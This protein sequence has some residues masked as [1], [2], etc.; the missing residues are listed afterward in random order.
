[1]TRRE[2]LR[3]TAHLC[4]HTLRN[5]AFFRAS[6]DAQ[7]A[8]TGEQ[9]WTTAHDNFLDIAVLEW[10]KVFA[11]EKRGKHHWGKV[12]NN[13]DVFM[14]GLLAH[15]KLTEPL[16]L[17][18]IQGMRAYRDKFIAHLDEENQMNIPN[19]SAAIKSSQYLYRWLLEEEDDCHAY[20]DA[21]PSAVAF[22]KSFLAEAK[23][24][25]AA[26]TAP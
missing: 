18:Y 5:M 8:W 25:Y 13:A 4:L 24:V 15:L 22:F 14:L 1:M 11:D 26:K 10:C 7:E 16:F 17:E 21:P 3:R 19:L 20:P 6:S 23:A 12:V 2:R 9:F